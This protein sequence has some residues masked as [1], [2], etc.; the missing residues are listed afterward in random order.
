M[1]GASASQA[2]GR[3]GSGRA[4]LP[5]L[6]PTPAPGLARATGSGLREL[7][8]SPRESRAYEATLAPLEEACAEALAVREVILL[9]SGRAGILA[10]LAHAGVSAGDE[11]IIPSYTAPCVPSAL[12]SAGLR[13]RVADVHPE[14]LVMTAETARA[15]LTPRTR[16]IL[17]TH[18]EGVTAPM[19]E[20]ADLAAAKGLAVVEDGAHAVGASCGSEPV[21]ARSICVVASLGKG[22]HINTLWGGLVA[23]NHELLA[24]AL[25]A[26]RAAF[27]PPSPPK[28]LAASALQ[29]ALSL[30]TAPRLYPLGLHPI[31]RAAAFF[32]VDLPTRVFEDP[33]RPP[34]ASQM[35]G[36]VPAALAELAF[37][38]IRALPEA[39]ARRRAIA[40]R[41]RARLEELGLPHQKARDPGDHPL[42][43]TLFHPRRAELQR[44]LLSLG[45]D[46]QPTWMRAVRDDGGRVDPE[47]ARAEREG[48][49]LPFYPDLSDS[50][51]NALLGAVERALGAIGS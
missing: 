18:T 46:T 28:L 48:L 43:V 21:G 42:A 14:H 9:G 16:A 47:A 1:L 36:R 24:R 30:A 32:G 13:V 29:V 44:A 6:R 17:P 26:Q 7:L 2:P 37:A 23:T 10:A 11:V 35:A 12:R 20:I 15:A 50:D 38:Q 39:R 34:S 22:K 41:L 27:A 33:G 45:I 4:Y 3:A 25:R 51:I 40:A 19:P 5:R 31:L 8:W 49:Y